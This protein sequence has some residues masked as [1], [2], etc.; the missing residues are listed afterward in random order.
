MIVST[1]KY[2]LKSIPAFIAFAVLSLRSIWQANWSD[3]LIA[4]KIRLRDFRTMTVWSSKA[5]M[6]AFRNSGI[7][8]R[9]M[10]ESPKLGTNQS[11]TW[12]TET[13]PTWSEAIAEIAR[14]SRD[15]S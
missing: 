10:I 3:G 2:T 7:H 12:E 6:L 11:Y 9:A 4:I 15:K 14:H 1:T 8:R 5:K 13:I